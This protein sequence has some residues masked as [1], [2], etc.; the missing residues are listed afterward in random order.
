MSGRLWP[1][2]RRRRV[3][4]RGWEGPH[5]C[6]CVFMCVHVC[7]CATLAGRSESAGAGAD[8][9]ERRAGAKRHVDADERIRIDTHAE[10]AG[11]ETRPTPATPGRATSGSP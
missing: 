3:D 4:W 8:V 11:L 7:A 1:T 2:S 9:I 10:K 5:V 6:V